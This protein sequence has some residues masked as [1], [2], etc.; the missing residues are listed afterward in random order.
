MPRLL[1]P[2]GTK[3][4]VWARDY[5]THPVVQYTHSYTV[6]FPNSLPCTACHKSWVGPWNEA[7]AH[8]YIQLCSYGFLILL[9]SLSSCSPPSLPPPSHEKRTSKSSNRHLWRERS[10]RFNKLTHSYYVDPFLPLHDTHIVL[11]R[12]TQ[13]ILSLTWQAKLLDITEDPTFAGPPHPASLLKVREQHRL[14]QIR[15]PLHAGGT[16]ASSRHVLDRA[17]QLYVGLLQL[18]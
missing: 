16:A 15:D 7:T 10:E 2:A 12:C 11:A 9:P 13:G 14:L 17:T 6:S 18:C 1:F 5:M 8:I 4:A 3:N